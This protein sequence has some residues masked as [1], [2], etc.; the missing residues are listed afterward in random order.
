MCFNI[1]SVVLLVLISQS[2]L[3]ES[4]IDNWSGSCCLPVCQCFL[5]PTVFSLQIL[6]LLGFL[7]QNLQRCLTFLLQLLHG[8]M[9]TTAAAIPL[10]RL[11]Q[12][13]NRSINAHVV[14]CQWL[15]FCI[16]WDPTD[17]YWSTFNYIIDCW[18]NEYISSGLCYMSCAWTHAYLGIYCHVCILVSWVVHR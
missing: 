17:V 11:K 13:I 5:Q 3:I 14:C 15:Y 8:S 12:S 10:L 1:E 16:V 4:N 6:D 18:T 9:E 7:G 2:T